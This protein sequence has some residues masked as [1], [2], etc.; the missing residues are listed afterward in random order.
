MATKKSRPINAQRQRDKAFKKTLNDLT[1][2]PA[3]AAILGA[4]ALLLF[5]AQWCEIYNTDAKTGEVSVSGFNCILAAW[6]GRYSDPSAI[7][8]DMAVPF[9]YY[10]KAVMPTLGTLSC[11]AFFASVGTFLLG[12]VTTV[13]AAVRKNHTLNLAAS[14]LAFVS[15]ILLILCFAVALSVASTELIPTYCNGNPACYIRSFALFPALVLLCVGAL[16]LFAFLN[17]RKA[18]A[19]YL[20][21]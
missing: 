17:Y 6:T 11:I 12:V 10:A 5:F 1:Y 14:A 15:G 3:I 21:P 7:Y 2:L 8:G 13:V 19:A 20:K 9:Y 18:K 16:H 4:I